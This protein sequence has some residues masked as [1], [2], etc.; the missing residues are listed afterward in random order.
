MCEPIVESSIDFNIKRKTDSGRSRRKSF[1]TVKTDS[2]KITFHCFCTAAPPQ[3]HRFPPESPE[4]LPHPDIKPIAMTAHKIEQT[5]LFFIRFSFTFFFFASFHPNMGCYDVNIASGTWN[6]NVFIHILH[7]ALFFLY[8][9]SYYFTFS[10][11]FSALLSSFHSFPA[12]S[13]HRHPSYYE[14]A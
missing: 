11:Y 12:G 8:I 6:V 14:R 2:I 10:A 13:S 3:K 9:F 5:T 7:F 4:L 1:S